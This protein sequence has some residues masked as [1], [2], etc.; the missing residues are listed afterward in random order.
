MIWW[1]PRIACVFFTNR[2]YLHYTQT[3]IYIFSRHC[4]NACTLTDAPRT[5]AHMSTQ[6][7]KVQTTNARSIG[8]WTWLYIEYVVV[9]VVVSFS[10]FFLSSSSSS[11]AVFF[12]PLLLVSFRLQHSKGYIF[13]DSRDRISAIKT[14]TPRA[15]SDD[16]WIDSN[17]GQMRNKNKRGEWKVKYWA[18]IMEQFQKFMHAGTPFDRW[19][20]FFFL[21]VVYLLS[22]FF[23]M[24]FWCDASVCVFFVV[25][26]PF[27][28]LHNHIHHSFAFRSVFGFH[29][30]ILRA[31]F[32]LFISHFHV[33]CST[34]PTPQHN[35]GSE[36]NM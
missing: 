20:G 16:R 28:L 14:W 7:S 32:E 34:T 35:H 29:F 27:G 19:G 10:F 24:I 1:P 12:V 4:C 17:H 3:Y 21:V 31:S 30:I 26:V 15:E 25:V 6:V 36:W 5:E 8:Q 18:K 13:M 9:V 33:L 23:L 2:T 22:F 11:V